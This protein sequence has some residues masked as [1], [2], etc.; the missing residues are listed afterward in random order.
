MLSTFFV[1]YSICLGYCKKH[2][3][4]NQ[5]V[6]CYEVMVLFT[7]E[8]PVTRVISQCWEF[9]PRQYMMTLQPKPPAFASGK[10]T[11]HPIPIPY[12]LD[13]RLV[14]RRGI[15]STMVFVLRSLNCF[16]PTSGLAGFAHGFLE[17]SMGVSC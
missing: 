13:K 12:R 9:A 4:V 15:F 3:S 17:T 6:S 16:T 5:L 7:K 1:L 10:L 14:Y 11:F 2:T 8:H